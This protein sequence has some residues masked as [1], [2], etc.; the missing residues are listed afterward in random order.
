MKATGLIVEYNPFHNGHL[1]HIEQ[2]K[3]K[4]NADCVIA[5]MSGNFLQRGEPALVDKFSRAKMAID[6]GVDLVIELPYLYAVQHSD[7]FSY[8]AVKL[9]NQLAVDTIIFGS[10]AGV[11]EPF[12]ATFRNFKQHESAFNQALKVALAD[13]KSFPKASQLAFAM[14]ND[15]S[16]ESLDLNQPNN[17]L[18]FSYL[19]AIEEINPSIKLDTLA[20][21]QNNYHD[22][23]LTTP[24]A[25]AT[26]IRTKIT[27]E[28]RLLDASR[29]A[30]PLRSHQYLQTYKEQAGIWHTWENYFPFLQYR[31]ISESAA[32]LALVHGVDEGLEHRLKRTA[33]QV[34]SFS[35]WL[36]LLKTKRYTYTRLQRMFVHLLTHTTKAIVNQLNQKDQPVA[37]RLLAMS[38]QGQRYLN[39]TKKTRTVP[40]YPKLSKNIPDLLKLD[41]RASDVYYLPLTPARR[42]KLRKQEIAAP[43]IN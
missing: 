13:G 31:V 32:S 30:L 25:S 12:H 40:I 33:T 6:Q 43:Y 35:E 15:A 23:Q 20:R 1:Y 14:I 18:G 2:A 24:F 39:S 17:I 7:I 27:T 41:E 10:E 5:C 38:E 29:L 28:E 8:G 37:I 26:S 42:N 21:K 22:V 11:M 16:K 34:T 4:S 19:K 9:L 36:E 3:H